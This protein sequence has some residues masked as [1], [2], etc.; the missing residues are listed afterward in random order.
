M[1]DNKKQLLGMAAAL[2]ANFIFG[3]SFVF[4][5]MA[6][7]VAHPLIILAVRFTVA[8]IVM[9]ILVLTRAVKI[10]LR[11]KKKGKLF[12]MCIAQPLLYF[13]FELYG[14]SL[15]S[16]ALSGIVISLVPV[17]VILMSTTFLGEKPTALQIICTIISIV[18]VAVISLISNDGGKNH[19][20]GIVL[21]AL[22]VLSASAFNILSRSESANFTPFERTYFMF[23]VGFVGFNTIAAVALR[24]EYVSGLISA[25][26]EWKFIVA[27]LYLAVLS[28]VFAFLMYNYSTT[29]ISAV[30]SSS[31]SNI[32]TVVSVLAGTIILKEDFS[33]AQLLLCIPIILGVWGVNFKQTNKNT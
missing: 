26:C 28:S 30:R 8:F 27:I 10:N 25:V 2:G 5:K 16:S 19:I 13:V 7:R 3:F 32:I 17:G 14:L 22:T 21:L 31:F 1:K 23:L 11:G 6:L 15:T 24:G 4:S 20:I 9:N 12:L 33:I 18:G 29:V